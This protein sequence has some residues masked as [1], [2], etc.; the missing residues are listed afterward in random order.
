MA[1]GIM[2]KKSNENCY[3]EELYKVGDIFITTNSEN[4][5]VRFGGTW[6]LFGPGRGLVCVNT[7]DTD[8]NTI[9][10]TGGSKTH[11]HLSPLTWFQKSGSNSYFGTTNVQGMTTVYDRDVYGAVFS[12]SIG[13]TDLS[14]TKLAYHTSVD[15]NLQPFI[16]CYIWIRTV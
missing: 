15:S 1:K 10:K 6:E 5:S 3:A 16:T 14:W 8:F 4:P 12:S 9:K 11:Y 7:S 2:F 13:T